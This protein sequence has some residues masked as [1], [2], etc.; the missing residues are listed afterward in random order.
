MSYMV[1]RWVF[2]FSLASVALFVSLTIS[3]CQ[4][5]S[6]TADLEADSESNPTASEGGTPTVANDSTASISEPMTVPVTPQ[7]DPS[8]PATH[9]GIGDPAPPL[10][11]AQ[12]ATGEPV[13]ALEDG[14]VYVV[15]FWAT[16]CPPCRTSMPHLSK[17]QKEYGDKVTFIGVTREDAETVDGFLEKEQSEGKTWRDVVQY[18]LALD[19]DDVTS[20]TYMKAAGQTGI[21]SAFI[22]GQDGRVEWIGHPMTM[23][24]PLAKIVSGDWDRNEAI[25]EAEKE[26]ALKVMARAL[27][28]L[29]RAE[30]WDEAIALLDATEAE[31]G[32]SQMLTQYRMFVLTRAGRTDELAAL[33]SEMVDQVWDNANA[34]NEIAWQIATGGREKPDLKLALKA[35]K[36]ACD[37][38]ENLNASS[39]D[40]LAR[41]FFEQGDLKAAIEWQKKAA[42]LNEG[43]IASIDAALKQYEAAIKKDEPASKEEPAPAKE[44]KP[45]TEEGKSTPTSEKS[46]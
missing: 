9:L 10:A 4:K 46:E 2:Q 21:P 29:A 27:N 5:S 38:H 37:L 43:A 16:W 30:K 8:T 33:E 18:R 24:S 28:S 22:V 26:A 35:A 31:N 20:T 36:R 6:S 45:E 23:D 13:A 19:K 32:K 14:Q 42:K 11:I 1:P 39:I 17:L 40:T 25:A 44:D 34:L 12:W 3:G 15:E 7:G 41:V